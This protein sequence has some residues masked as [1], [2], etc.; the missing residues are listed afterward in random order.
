MSKM[1]YVVIILACLFLSTIAQAASFDC[2]KAATK[3]EKLICS[4]TQLSQSDEELMSAYTKALKETPDTESLKKQQREWLKNVRNSCADV[5]CLRV[6]Y[7]NRIDQLASVKKM[8]YSSPSKTANTPVQMGGAMQGNPLTLTRTVSTIAGNAFP[9][10]TTF[11][12]GIGT[13]ARFNMPHGITTDGTNLYVTEN[14]WKGRGNCTIRKIVIA[15][16][17]VTTLAGKQDSCEQTDGIGTEARFADPTGITTDGTNLYV[18]DS[19]TIRKI[20]IATGE[21]TT[22]AGTEGQEGSTDRTGAMA[23]FRYLTGITTDRTNLYVTDFGNH[24]IRKIVIATGAVTTVAGRAGQKGFA[25]GIGTAARF[26][27]PHGITTDGTNLYVTE[28]MFAGTSRKIVIATGAVT[29]I[30]GNPNKIGNA[31]GIGAAASFHD[32]R[33][34]TTDGTNLYVADSGNSII[35][36]I[37]IATGEVTKFAGTGKTFNYG[38]DGTIATASFGYPHN[39]TTDGTN[40]YV[41]DSDTIRKIAI[42]SRSVVTIAGRAGSIMFADGIGDAA[43]FRFPHGITTDRVNLYVVDNGNNVIRKI[44]IATG[45]VTTIAGMAE[46]EGSADGIGAAARFK[47]PFDITT[48]GANL[49]VADAG[50]NIIRKIVI[51]TGLVTTIAGKAGTG[52]FADGKGTAARFSNPFGITTDGINLYVADNSNQSI[53]KI[54]L[55]SGEV[56]T[57]AGTAG[58]RE[59]ADGTGAAA[60]FDEPCGIT[61]DGTNL[62]VVDS[63]NRVVR[64]IVVNTGEVTTIAGRAGQKGFVDGTGAIARFTMPRSITTDGTNLYVIDYYTIRK[65]VIATGAVTTIAGKAGDSPGFSSGDGVGSA[66]RFHDPSG[67]TTDGSNL[68]VSDS[69]GCNTIRKI[70]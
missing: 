51:A 8:K 28:N 52:S 58:K 29:T 67:I 69:V 33:G 1:R 30:A 7:K 53:R 18:T 16:G 43:Q 37:V 48:D 57:I 59:F 32:P 39:I 23:R 20:V 68:Y 25:D 15:T 45:Q 3:V 21:V 10:P 47:S 26:K 27:M 50:N 14:T 2:T 13:A 63:F 12:D 6:E 64:K 40:L 65:I 60:H 70:Q 19:G 66:T 31:D 9:T 44:V 35:R 46:E 11:L 24:N 62:Y 22:I 41:T 56:T 17:A 4:D 5:D 49:Y 61:T 36:K 55:A 34:I 54:V 38:K 42:A